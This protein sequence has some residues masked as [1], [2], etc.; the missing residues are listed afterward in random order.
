MKRYN[1]SKILVLVTLF[2]VSMLVGCGSL[3][4]VRTFAD[5]TKKLSTAFDPMLSGSASSC[6]NKYTRKK[7]ITSSNFNPDS[8]KN[9]AKELCGSIDE[10]NK[11]IS[12]INSLLKQYA[13]TLSALADDGLPSY[14]TQLGD[15]QN[16]IGRIKKANTQ[17]ALIDSKKMDAIVSLVEF[18]SRIA[19]Q[20]MQKNAIRDLISHED[21]INAIADALSDYA[22][23][24]YKAWLKDEKREINI[25]ETALDGYAKN[26]P[27]AANYLKTILF[28]E[29]QQIEGREK[30]VDAFVKAVSALKRSNSELRS[31]FDRMSDKDL[32]NQ[33]AGFAKEV[34]DLRKQII[35]SF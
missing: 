27:L 32:A 34:T 18:L 14:K 5:E 6:I 21:A 16:S 31:K 4:P 28:A 24:N 30:T 35:D 29:E 7:L 25:L 8:A 26:E 22:T 3:A 17:D 23:Y 12:N 11:V 15:L 10:D 33:I 20:H 2:N 19:T 13:D 1:E 9:D